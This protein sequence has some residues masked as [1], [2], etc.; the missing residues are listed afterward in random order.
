MSRRIALACSLALTV[1]VAFAVASL[2]SQSGWLQA[3]SGPALEASAL[4]AAAQPAGA[5]GPG[6]LAPIVITEYVYQDIPVIV[7]AGW[8]AVSPSASP[9]VVDPQ[10]TV[11]AGAVTGNAGDQQG[12]PVLQ[13]TSWRDD[14]DDDDFDDDRHRR[15]SGDDDDDD[16][17]DDDD[18]ERSRGH[19]DDD[20][21]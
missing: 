21:D 5:A 12:Q 16:D 15:S 17:H 19:D 18:D 8:Q 4:E 6:S 7:P 3:Q 2:A 11:P 9:Q 14:D 10:A 20:D 1:V 13:P